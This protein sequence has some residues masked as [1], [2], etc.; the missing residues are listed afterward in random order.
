MRPRNDAP[1]D[2]DNSQTGDE[3]DKLLAKGE[4]WLS[5]HPEKEAIT[6]RYLKF[7]PSLVRQALARLVE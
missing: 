3:L 2:L 1:D 7:Q 4:G 5:S 6:R